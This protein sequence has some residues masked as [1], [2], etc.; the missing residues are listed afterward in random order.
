M[1]FKLRKYNN[2]S[3]RLIVSPEKYQI[4]PD[5]AGAN[6]VQA[7]NRANANA[8]TSMVAAGVSA[9][10][11]VGMI[12]GPLV[13]LAGNALTSLGVFDNKK[14]IATAKKNAQAAA[15]T[16]EAFLNNQ[17]ESALAGQ[18]LPMMANGTKSVEPD[19]KAKKVQDQA[20]SARAYTQDWI[21]NRKVSNP[22]YQ[23][24]IDALKNQKLSNVASTEVRVLP[25]LEQ[26]AVGT[27]FKDSKTGKMVI[28]LD[29]FKVGS[30]KTFFHN[31][32]T[33]EFKHQA[34]K[35]TLLPYETELISKSIDTSTLP[36]ELAEYY[37]DADEVSARIQGLRRRAGFKP[38]QKVTTDQLKRF[39][40]QYNKEVASSHKVT[41]KGDSQVE[42]IKE[43][44]PDQGKLLNL[45]NNLSKV[46]EDD[47]G[48]RKAAK[49]MKFKKC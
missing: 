11:G 49:G 39:W 12:A 14:K 7:N 21:K 9:I 43:L 30:D 42:D 22:D 1:N 38:D 33:H 31:T 37:K 26:N 44:I 6:A 19:A 23:K 24:Q 34:N 8:V 40:D 20:E 25:Q 36:P 46:E 27:S 10:P 28:E 48:L 18:S 3:N 41:D 47:S 15:D 4:N 32:P 35:G 45:L 16:D 13:S 2:G 29:K 17:A 5:S